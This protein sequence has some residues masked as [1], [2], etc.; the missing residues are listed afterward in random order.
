MTEYIERDTA[1]RNSR[2]YN[3]GGSYYNTQRAVPVKVINSIPAADVA[4]VVHGRW[5]HIRA[6]DDGNDLYECSVC[7]KGDC[8]HPAVKVSYCWNCGARMDGDA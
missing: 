8:H 5:I 1:I 3:L 7:H 2:E 4:P 6:E